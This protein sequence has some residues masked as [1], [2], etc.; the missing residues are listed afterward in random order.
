MVSIHNKNNL[1]WSNSLK[2][3][4]SKVKTIIKRPVFNVIPYNMHWMDKMMTKVFPDSNLMNNASTQT[5]E[6]IDSEIT[7]NDIINVKVKR[8]AENPYQ[9]V[10][11]E[12]TGKSR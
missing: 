6:N 3:A 4:K 8:E 11:H 5:A 12:T 9:S 1:D 2:K 10:S 7:E